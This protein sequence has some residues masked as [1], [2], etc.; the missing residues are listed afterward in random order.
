MIHNDDELA[1][2]RKQLSR[3]EEALAALRQ[4]VLPKNQR[5]FEVL[6]E[7]YFDQ[8]SALRAEIDAYLR[9]SNGSLPG[10][11]SEPDQSQKV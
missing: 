8:A 4:D 11:A 1:V 5:N 6:S 10:L 7:G 9:R 2:V 3:V